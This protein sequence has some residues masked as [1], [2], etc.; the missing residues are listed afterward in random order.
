MVGSRRLIPPDALQ[1]KDYCTNPGFNRSFLHHQ[2]SPPETLV[3]KWGTTWARNGR[4][5]LPE[6]A[7]LPRNIQ[8]SFTCRKS[9]IWDKGFSSLPREGVLRIFSPWKIRWLRS[10]LNPRTWVAKAS[11]LPLDHRSGNYQS[12]QHALSR[13]RSSPN[14]VHNLRR[15]TVNRT[16]L[17]EV[18]IIIDW[19]GLKNS[20][21]R[22][23]S[24]RIA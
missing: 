2:L 15:G 18:A 7:R 5:I 11:T 12:I 22:C 9:A 21:K 3:V 10:G 6:N 24:K 23:N 8:G 20:E 19:I 1:P 17:R 14:V 4:W 13:K 16:G